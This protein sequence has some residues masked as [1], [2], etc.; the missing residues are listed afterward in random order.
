MLIPTNSTAYDDIMDNSYDQGYSLDEC[1]IDGLTYDQSDYMHL[2]DVYRQ[3]IDE[4]LPDVCKLALQR[5]QHYFRFCRPEFFQKID[6]KMKVPC[7]CCGV[8]VER[9]KVDCGERPVC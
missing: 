2:V 1:K 9:L 6:E 5:N 7:Y 4:H 8:P 3:F